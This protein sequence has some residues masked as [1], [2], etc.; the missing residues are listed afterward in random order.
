LIQNADRVAIQM[1]YLDDKQLDS[2]SSN[3]NIKLSNFHLAFLFSL[4]P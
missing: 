4:I 2:K 3:Q 1:T